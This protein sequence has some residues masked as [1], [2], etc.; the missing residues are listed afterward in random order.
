MIG[1]EDPQYLL[2]Q[3]VSRLIHAL[4]D[5]NSLT[6]KAADRP[7]RVSQSLITGPTRTKIFRK[8]NSKRRKKEESSSEES[9]SERDDSDSEDS[10][11]TH[12]STE[13]SSYK[14]LKSK[15]KSRSKSKSESLENISGDENQRER[16]S[17]SIN[18]RRLS[19]K[20]SGLSET[21]GSASGSSVIKIDPRVGFPK[22]GRV[23][24]RKGK[25]VLERALL[26]PSNRTKDEWKISLLSTVLALH[27][28]GIF[29]A[30]M[31]IHFEIAFHFFQNQPQSTVRTGEPGPNIKISRIFRPSDVIS[32]LPL[33][34]AI[35]NFGC[36][37]NFLEEMSRE[38][39]RMIEGYPLKKEYSDFISALTSDIPLAEYAAEEVS[40]GVCV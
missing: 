38:H 8:R 29:I 27:P 2:E 34:F 40:V 18:R 11:S 20:S 5:K 32:N 39:S 35:K 14:I 10:D 33:I 21:P 12:Q 37:N 26:C 6:A 16:E 9:V 7:K 31:N 24:R 3:Y 30:A 13:S 15:R 17:L 4:E 1:T 19:N 28:P 36:S 22:G 25:D 23:R